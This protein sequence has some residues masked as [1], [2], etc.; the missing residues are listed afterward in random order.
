[1][2]HVESSY[3]YICVIYFTWVLFFSFFYFFTFWHCVLFLKYWIPIFVNVVNGSKYWS[4]QVSFVVSLHLY[5]HC[6]SMAAPA[7]YKGTLQ[8]LQR[9]CVSFSFAQFF[10]EQYYIRCTSCKLCSM[11]FF[12]VVF[13]CCKKYIFHL[14]KN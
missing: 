4:M 12:Y 5:S 10:H 14:H 11:F 8:S 6:I 13:H 9:M 1:M 2:S 3:V 7:C